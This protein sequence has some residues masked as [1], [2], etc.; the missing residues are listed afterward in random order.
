MFQ[1]AVDFLVLV[2]TGAL[3]YL[4]RGSQHLIA[5]APM[6]DGCAVT[7]AMIGYENEHVVL[8]KFALTRFIIAGSDLG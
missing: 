6:S 2:I 7:P 3:F 8:V 4:E 1:M 5:G